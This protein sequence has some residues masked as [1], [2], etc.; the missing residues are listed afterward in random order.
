MARATLIT[1]RASD[2]A[3]VQMFVDECDAELK[4]RGEF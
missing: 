1:I 3:N 4:G 2:R